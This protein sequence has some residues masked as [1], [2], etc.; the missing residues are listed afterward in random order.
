MDSNLNSTHPET[1]LGS[2]AVVL[3]HVRIPLI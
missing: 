1:A 2:G 3:A